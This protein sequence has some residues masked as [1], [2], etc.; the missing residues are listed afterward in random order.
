VVRPLNSVILPAAEC[1]CPLT[2]TKFNVVTV[3]G[4]WLLV[5]FGHF[6]EKKN[7]V[8]VATGKT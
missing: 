7:T 1:H 3:S 2:G 8:T 5:S 6:L 4:F